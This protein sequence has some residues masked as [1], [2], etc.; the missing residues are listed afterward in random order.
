MGDL[1]FSICLPTYNSGDR[2]GVTLEDI[3]AQS[4]PNYEVIVSDNASLDNTAEVVAGFKDKRIK[5]FRNEQNVGFAQNLNVCA[6]KAT[7]DILFLMS[8][9][10]RLSRDAL[11]DT[12]DAF[13][14][15]EDIGAVTRPY[16]WFGRSVDQP[17]R[18]KARPLGRRNT[19][20]SVRDS[21]DAVIELF[22]TADNPAGMA[23]R[24]KFMDRPFHPDP[25]VEFVYPFASILK[26]HK[27]VFLNKY[28]MACPALT[29]SGSQN[30]LVYKKSPVQCWAD[31]F[32]T[33]F[34]EKEFADLKAA[35]IGRFV[36]TNYVGLAQIKNYAGMRALLREIRLLVKYRPLNLLSPRFWF[37]SIGAIAI[38]GFILKKLVMIFKKEINSRIYND[39]K[40]GA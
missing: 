38:P 23:F 8:A 9:K 36:A 28:T 3:L 33:V 11:K 24:K 31:L 35:C 14:F 22:R 18:I 10:S 25:F 34:C 20:V 19:V 6:G 27:V 21:Y 4:Y 13:M 17:V 12:R 37:F 1:T 2:I 40:L 39:V 7:G 29:Y 26:K 5:Y 15:S 16:F 30:P 32:E